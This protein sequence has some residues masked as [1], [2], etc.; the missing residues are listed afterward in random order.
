M[1][2]VREGVA[3][4]DNIPSVVIEFEREESVDGCSGVNAPEGD[5]V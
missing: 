4:G 1:E 5:C 2:D 3:P